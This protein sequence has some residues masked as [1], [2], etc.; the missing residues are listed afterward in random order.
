LEQI[1]NSEQYSQGTR[2]R[3]EALAVVIRGKQPAA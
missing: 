1:A 2:S 3:A